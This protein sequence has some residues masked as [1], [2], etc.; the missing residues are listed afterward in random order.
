MKKTKLKLKIK[1]QPKS[2]SKQ[3]SGMLS[4]KSRCRVRTLSD[5]GYCHF[6]NHQSKVLDI[7]EEQ[8]SICFENVEKKDILE[9]GHLVHIDCLKKGYKC[10]CPVCRHPLS[11]GIPTRIR[12]KI[13]MNEMR[14]KREREQ[15]EYEELIRQEAEEQAWILNLVNNF[16]SI[17]NIIDHEEDCQCL[18]CQLR[19][20]I[21]NS[22][23]QITR[24]TSTIG[25]EEWN[26]SY[27]IVE[28]NLNLDQ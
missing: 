20:N 2:K 11:R 26:M 13:L 15:E 28:Q 4:N 6:H 25:D 9:C 18:I 21:G 24:E 7:K 22:S 27:E 8:C 16:I 5:S 14:L 23:I 3:C 19:N 10:E 1:T 12:H 17:D